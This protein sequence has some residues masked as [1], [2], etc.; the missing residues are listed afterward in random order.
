MSELTERT[1]VP[2]KT[3]AAC[4]T[5]I[6]GLHIWLNSQ[7]MDIKSR[8]TTIEANMGRRFTLMDMRLWVSELQRLN[9]TLK[10]P[11]VDTGTGRDI[12]N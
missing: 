10:I 12:N 4:I 7:L 11:P 5:L 8:L 1:R 9:G 2:L 6:V 3:A